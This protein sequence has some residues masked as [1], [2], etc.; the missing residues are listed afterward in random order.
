[1]FSCFTF[2]QE[3]RTEEQPEVDREGQLALAEE[4]Q[5]ESHRVREREIY[6]I[7][8][9]LTVCCYLL[10]GSNRTAEFCC[11][12]INTSSQLLVLSLSIYQQNI[13][14]RNITKSLSL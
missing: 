5:R 11:L 13:F 14:R 4:R 6:S 2:K 7:M 3:N 8:S 12:Q 9:L 10:I 1:V